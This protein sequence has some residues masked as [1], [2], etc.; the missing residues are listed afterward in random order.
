M[1]NIETKQSEIQQS[2]SLFMSLFRDAVSDSQVCRDFYELFLPAKDDWFIKAKS[3]ADKTRVKIERN[4]IS[5]FKNKFPNTEFV[6]KDDITTKTNDYFLIDSI[7]GV[8]NF[9]RCIPEFASSISYF[10]NRQIVSS[11]IFLPVYG[12]ILSATVGQGAY[13]TNSNGH[14]F[15]LRMLDPGTTHSIIS[16][17][18]NL[19]IDDDISEESTEYK[20]NTIIHNAIKQNIAV[21]NSHS[22]STEFAYLTTGKINGIVAKEIKAKSVAAGLLIAQESGAIIKSLNDETID[23]DTA[24]KDKEFSILTP[25]LSNLYKK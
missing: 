17:T 12:Y 5:S 11:L 19:Y 20:F 9:V 18:R 21:R 8:Q 13:M 23:I 25:S 24:L 16:T 14:C 3:F 7:S 10:Q 22:I 2:S 6:L 15:K 1:D 4:I